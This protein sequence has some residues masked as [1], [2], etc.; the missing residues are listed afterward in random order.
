MRN[1]NRNQTIENRGHS[2]KELVRQKEHEEEDSHMKDDA[3]GPL[4]GRNQQLVI[5]GVIAALVLLLVLVVTGEDEEEP[6]VVESA[7]FASGQPQQNVSKAVAPAQASSG[8]QKV[9]KPAVAPQPASKQATSPSN[10]PANVSITKPDWS[11][12]ST[13][14]QISR[15]LAAANKA[16]AKYRLTTPAGDNAHHYFE[17]VLALDPGNKDAIAG[18]DEI[19][20]HYRKMAMEAI[21]QGLPH[22]AETYVDRGLSIRPDDPGLLEIK[23]N[24]APRT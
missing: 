20:D 5:Y 17:E 6:G 23:H 1:H 21:R 11:T 12:L 24:V 4:G 7:P 16:M 22:E 2:S 14:E 13:Q 15:L 9:S 19:V 3:A 8:Q 10:K 18:L